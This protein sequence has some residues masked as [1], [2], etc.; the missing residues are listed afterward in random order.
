M[1][2]SD[3]RK[4]IKKLVEQQQAE[5]RA[6]LLTYAD[7]VANGI[8]DPAIR[9]SS[10]FTLN[11][12][13]YAL[14]RLLS[15]EH[16]IEMRESLNESFRDNMT[17]AWD[18]SERKTVALFNVYFDIIKSELG[19]DATK[20]FNNELLKTFFNGKNSDPMSVSRRVWDIS[21]QFRE[22]MVVHA[23]ISIA[24]GDSA[25]TM[26]RRV[27]KYLNEPDALFRRV[28]KIGYDSE[29]NR[30]KKYRWSKRALNYSPGPGKY[31]SAYK[32]ALRYSATTINQTYVASDQYRWNQLD[33]V[34][35][36][37][38]ILSEQH[39]TYDICDILQGRYPKWFKW[40][41]WHPFCLC[42]AIPVLM[43]QDKFREVLKGE[44]V[45][46]VPVD[47][48]P[49]NFKTWMSTNVEKLHA[50]KNNPWF[51]QDNFTK[52]SVG[53]KVK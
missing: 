47:K 51:I 33:F 45:K 8:N 2:E 11:G 44:K 49:G 25:Q 4:K 18:L 14:R 31:R 39:P 9:F 29:G 19:V 12:S 22:E 21:T 7:A 37:D 28:A 46:V 30:V 27:R 23:G 10:S 26:S 16:F 6:I 15:G 5:M 3:F 48:L 20:Q 36:Y 38:V 32:N 43:E 1:N 35:G 34:L 24:N 53:Y 41:L 52:T 50:S 40:T 42:H 17:R 13:N